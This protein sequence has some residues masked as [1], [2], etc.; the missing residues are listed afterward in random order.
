MKG[1][2]FKLIASLTSLVMVLAVMSVGIWAATSASLSVTTK[3]S[4][5]ANG[6]TGTVAGSIANGTPSGTSSYSG[7]IPLGT[8]SL[9]AWNI[10]TITLQEGKNCTVTIKLTVSQMT[11]GKTITPTLSVKYGSTDVTSGSTY[12]TNLKITYSKGSAITAAGSITTTVTFAAASWTSSVAT[13]EN[14]TIALSWTSA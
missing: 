14:V 4:F 1:K 6:F 8:A 7:E 13:S 11:S 10:G 9:S 12:G 2:K 3:V 5:T